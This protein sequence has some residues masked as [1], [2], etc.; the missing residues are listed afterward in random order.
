MSI[1][2]SKYVIC[3]KI[4]SV[5]AAVDTPLR[6]YFLFFLVNLKQHVFDLKAQKPPTSSVAGSSVLN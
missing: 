2:Q 5:F 1:E 6:F 4:T 3:I